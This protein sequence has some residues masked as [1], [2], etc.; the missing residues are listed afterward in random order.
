MVGHRKTD[1]EILTERENPSFV[2]KDP[3]S[4]DIV[5]PFAILNLV[6]AL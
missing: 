4:K 5:E 1:Q 2:Q 3:A 6:W